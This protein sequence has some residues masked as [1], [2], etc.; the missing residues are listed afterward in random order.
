MKPLASPVVEYRLM[1][2]GELLGG[3]AFGLVAVSVEDPV[4]AAA[5][6]LGSAGVFG[7][8]MYLTTY[9]RFAR[10]AVQQ[11]AA[12]LTAEREPHARTR[13]RIA[14]PIAAL[15]VF[16]AAN[17]V[18]MAAPALVGGVAAGNGAAL[19]LTSRWL[20]RWEQAH[21]S[22][23]LRE[24]RWRWSRKGRRGWGRG[25]G[26]MDPQDFYVVASTDQGA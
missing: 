12:P 22:R 21:Q 1:G 7:T 19:L 15:L 3:L 13:R 16:F 5:W 25:R 14:M 17:A 24:P 10:G 11:P 4:A 23:L 20:R 18:L 9:R 26:V 8:W 2:I 6:L